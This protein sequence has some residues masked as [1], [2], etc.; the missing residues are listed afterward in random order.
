MHIFFWRPSNPS[1]ID[2][3]PENTCD[4]E[5]DPQVPNDGIYIKTFLPI[6]PKDG[7]TVALYL[8]PSEWGTVFLALDI[9]RRHNFVNMGPKD[10]YLQ[11]GRV[12]EHLRD[13]VRVE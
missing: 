10:F 4:E 1:S 2:A 13:Q 7:E 5:D 8:T 9:L 12:W 6:E 11:A 3:P